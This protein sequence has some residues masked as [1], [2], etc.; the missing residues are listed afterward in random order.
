[1]ATFTPTQEQQKA[2]DCSGNNILL[3]AA[4]GSGKTK[5]LVDRVMRILSETGAPERLLIVTF[6]KK[7]AAEM[8]FKI[9]SELSTRLADDPN[10][11]KLAQ[12]S[13]K[14]DMA[15]ISTIDSF[16][17]KVVRENAGLLE[18]TPT[19]SIISDAELALFKTKAMTAAIEE[20]HEKKSD[21]FFAATELFM[22]DRN[23]ELIDSAI[24]SLYDKSQSQSNPDEYLKGLL[25]MY[26]EDSHIPETIWGQ[27]ILEHITC[28][29]DCALEKYSLGYSEVDF[30]G[31]ETTKKILED[32]R[33]FTEVFREK[34]QNI[35]TNDDWDKILF[36][37]SEV[38]NSQ[39]M[40]VT[41]KGNKEYK[42]IS[43]KAKLFRDRGKELLRKV[44]SLISTLPTS[45]QHAEENKFIY[46]VAESFF[47]AVSL[48]RKYL[49]EL[50]Q[51]S[52]VLEFIDVLHKGLDLLQNNP[53]LCESYRQSF[54]EILIDEY[55]DTNNAQDEFFRLLSNGKNLFMVG[56]V[57]QSIYAFRDANPEIFTDKFKR[58]QNTDDGIALTL[59][60]NFRSDKDIIDNVNF[61]FEQ[62]M[63]EKLGGIDYKNDRLVCHNDEIKEECG[64][65]IYVGEKDSTVQDE[66]KF[67]AE[68]IEKSTIENRNN[69]G[70]FCILLRSRT[71]AQ[72]YAEALEY[73]NIPYSI[74]TKTNPLKADETNLLT[75][76]LTVIDNP[77]DD[78]SLVAVLFSPMFGFSIDEISKIRM[79]DRSTSI[80]QNINSIILDENNELYEKLKSFTDKIT[81]YRTLSSCMNIS[82]FI[83]RIIHETDFDHIAKCLKNAENVDQNITDLL[84]YAESYE[85]NNTIDLHGFL[86]FL[87]Y[88]TKNQNDTEKNV[89]SGTG[90]FVKIMTVHASKGLEFPVV[91]VGDLFST[92]NRD[93]GQL[94][95]HKTTGLGMKLINREKYQNY[96]T[97][98][99]TAVKLANEKDEAAEKL[100]LL[101][102]ALTR[103]RNK[104]VLCFPDPSRSGFTASLKSN[105]TTVNPAKVTL[106]PYEIFSA[107]S[108]GNLLVYSLFRHN[109][110]TSLRDKFDMALPLLQSDSR[111]HSDIIQGL[112]ES[113][114]INNEP[115]QDAIIDE[116]QFHELK[117]RADYIYPYLEL[118]SF[119]AKRSA[120]FSNK[121]FN[122]TYVAKSVPLFMQGD[123]MTP[124]AR[125]T[126]YHNFLQLCNFKKLAENPTAEI[127]R[128]SK[129]GNMTKQE[130]EILNPYLLSKF[131][132]SDI[133]QAAANADE[134]YRE[135]EFNILVK[136]EVVY[137]NVPDYA[138]DEEILI[139]GM[140]DLVFIKD[141]KAYIVDYKTDRVKDI[142]D[143]LEIYSKQME[144]YK[145]AVQEIFDI[146]VNDT[147][148]YSLPLGTAISTL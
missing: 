130:I 48:Y 32:E 14:I 45:E 128:V 98:G 139:Q 31:M 37:Y 64:F 123:I 49:D 125:G 76:L 104:I 39:G 94:R 9:I 114:D 60:K 35:K 80:W 62:L 100:R 102:V 89:T 13:M 90:N 108:F 51:E 77:L 91:F 30:E 10:N 22:T 18:L 140:I 93:R 138:K 27:T 42:D 107:N 63:Q 57:K 83:R 34:I 69:Y 85:S 75:A 113:T 41:W 5:V 47:E 54:D 44:A 110:L 109:E 46:P 1:M 133:G 117:K 99:F 127:E 50:K 122:S 78:V 118:N 6:T 105:C 38:I 17:I 71:K 120:S 121:A 7:A 87:F 134:I 11:Y 19:F 70:D 12:A 21:G 84:K 36:H 82:A 148:L 88:V 112:F 4:A 147:L 65:Q 61:I 144:F 68:Y 111:A 28:I 23:D 16:C 135:L 24:Y 116:E 40:F 55:Q 66:A 96:E 73:Y 136:P 131:A 92:G 56:D 8:K 86:R 43:D 142:H 58:F 126:A 119:M 124:A 74:D 143:L 33:D 59:S 146:P 141:K 29:L 97:L 25:N 103:A 101:Y 26:K 52:G 106:H 137:D 72:Y 2:I 15:Q 145:I 3:S 129:Q 95:L 79:V 132:K 81:E 67:I 20:M 53:A 115:E